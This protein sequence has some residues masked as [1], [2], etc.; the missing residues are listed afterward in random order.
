MSM[1]VVSSCFWRGMVCSQ[2]CVPEEEEKG[3]P[4]ERI[5]VPDSDDLRVVMKDTVLLPIL[6]EYIHTTHPERRR[7][8]S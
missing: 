4:G 8:K 2:V 6:Q 5:S 7:R 1:G 3:L